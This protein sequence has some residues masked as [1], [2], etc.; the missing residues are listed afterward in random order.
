MQV[1][2][3]EKWLE[4]FNVL[5][6]GLEKKDMVMYFNDLLVN[7]FA[8]E[9]GFAGQVRKSDSDYLTVNFSNVKGSKTD[10]VTG[11]KVKVVTR[12][13]DGKAVHTLS[14][15]RRHDGGDEEY[16]FYNRQNPAFVRVLVPD[17]TRLI[18]ISGYDRP[19]YE[20]LIN[21]EGTGF[22]TDQD[23]ARYE[24]S[25]NYNSESGI[26]EFTESGKKGFGFWLIT[27]PGRSKSVELKYEVPLDED[28]YSLYVQKQPGIVLE[29]FEAV[30]HKPRG[31]SVVSFSPNLN[32]LGDILGYSAPLG[33]DVI[34][35]A[36]FK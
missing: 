12:L 14:I 21:Y 4:I 27:D 23:L 35:N 34:L 6:S 18:S 1:I 26:W 22:A 5:V 33:Q 11:S 20:P 28:K 32:K 19:D 8:I 9:N 3:K 10:A 15:S 17:G 2:E 24:S 16:G 30:I 31:R 7:S 25:Y 36:S 13:E 29:N